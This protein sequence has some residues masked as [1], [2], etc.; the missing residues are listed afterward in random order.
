MTREYLSK[1]IDLVTAA[2]G[3]VA[4]LAW[5]S[6]IQELLNRLYPGSGGLVEK[7]L[8]A[9]IITGIAVWVTT[10]LAKLHDRIA[11]KEEAAKKRAEKN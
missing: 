2:F 6:A 9:A 7:F 4:A 10:S 1:I 8:Y 3:L 11:K 5:N